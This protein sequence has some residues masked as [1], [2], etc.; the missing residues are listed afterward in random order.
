MCMQP[1]A[2]IKKVL[3]Y[4]LNCHSAKQLTY[5]VLVSVKIRRISTDKKEKKENKEE[6]ERKEEEEEEEEN[7]EK[8]EEKKLKQQATFKWDIT[9]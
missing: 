9:S 7:K 6:E 2:H 4:G 1:P 3:L 5:H 8:E